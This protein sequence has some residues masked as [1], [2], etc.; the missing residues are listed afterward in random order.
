MVTHTRQQVLCDTNSLVLGEK[1]GWIQQQQHTHTHIYINYKYIY[2][3]T[4]IHTHTHT[5]I[6][7][8]SSST[9]PPHSYE[10]D[11]VLSVYMLCRRYYV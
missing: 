2:A 6:S 3:Y 9:T 8:S 1:H 7:S 5:H 4:H 11:T 10:F